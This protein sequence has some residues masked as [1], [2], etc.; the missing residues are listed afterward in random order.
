M[1]KIKFEADKLGDWMVKN[2][3][4]FH[5]MHQLKHLEPQLVQEDDNPT[6]LIIIPD[7]DHKVIVC[8][9]IGDDPEKDAYQPSI[10]ISERKEIDYE[11]TSN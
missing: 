7:L 1:I 9:N 8:D 10:I 4:V 6:T 5:L 3:I 11:K 2:N